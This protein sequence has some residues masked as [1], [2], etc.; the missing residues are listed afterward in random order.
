M[1]ETHEPITGPGILW[2]IGQIN[3]RVEKE[4]AKTNAPKPENKDEIAEAKEG[5]KR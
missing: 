1:N 2:A 3:K 4:L 5:L